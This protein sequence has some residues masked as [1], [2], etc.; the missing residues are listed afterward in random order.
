MDLSKKTKDALKHWVF[1]MTDATVISDSDFKQVG[2]VLDE[3]QRD[4]RAA[5]WDRAHT[6]LCPGTNTGYCTEHRNPFMRVHA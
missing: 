2:K 3:L 4:E 6:T 5:G 1:S